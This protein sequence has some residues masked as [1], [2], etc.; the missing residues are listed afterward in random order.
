VFW[1]T[2]DVGWGHRTHLRRVW[3][4]WQ[5]AAHAGDVRRCADVSRTAAAFW[6]ICQT[7]LVSIFYTAPHRDPRAHESWANGVPAR[8]D[9]SRLRLARQAWANRSTPE[10]WMW[11]HRVIGSKTLSHRRYLVADGDRLH[12]DDAP[13]P[14]RSRPP[15]PGSCAKTAPRDFLPTIVDEEG[16][17]VKE[18]GRGRPISSIKRAVGQSMLAHDLGRQRSISEGLNWEKF[19]DRY[20]RG[21]R[22]RPPR[23]PDGYY[24]IMGRNRRTC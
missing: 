18:G 17:P 16:R 10:A 12:H 15:R 22:F 1:C 23:W 13:L 2:A 5:R 21:G 3:V 7:H 9:L 8:Y 14:G 11:Y 24:W 6:N 19:D 4:R 20:L